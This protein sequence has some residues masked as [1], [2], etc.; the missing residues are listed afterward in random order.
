MAKGTTDQQTLSKE[1]A[2]EED[3]EADEEYLD[4]EF[5]DEEFSGMESD[6]ALS[7][8]K[9]AF[10]KEVDKKIAAL[11]KVQKNAHIISDRLFNEI[12]NF[13]LSIQD[14]SDE[15]RLALLRSIPNKVGYK[16][17][18]KFDIRTVD[19]SNVLIFKQVEG[20]ALDACQKVVKY[21][22]IFD[23]VRN[24]HELEVGNDHPKAKTLYKRVWIK[25]G[26]S[27]PRWVCEIF[28]LFCP[29]CIRSKPRKK[30][31]AGHQPL[32]TRGMNVRAQIDLIDYQ[33]MPDGPYNYVLDYQDHGIKFCQLR[34]LTQ[35]T[36]R[37]VA[38]ELI[39]I[40]CIFGPP[41]ILQAD[42]GKEFSH[43]ASKSR[44]VQID[45]EVSPFLHTIEVTRIFGSLFIW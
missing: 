43:G 2:I 44:H 26:K 30:A 23:V 39:Q 36:H 15:V 29:V 31:K 8:R 33:S 41:S 18:K 7:A 5:A 42:N 25:Y 9:E 10:Y 37:A 19:T 21:S 17:M 13:M 20:E 11:S 28:P 3:H 27:I 12:Y 24:I 6:A 1:A 35:R 14:A 16:W 38:L 34:A 45:E 40:F 22:K 4:E 32:L